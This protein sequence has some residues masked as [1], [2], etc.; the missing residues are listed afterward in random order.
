M[1]THMLEAIFSWLAIP[2]L[3]VLLLA[4]MMSAEVLLDRALRLFDPLRNRNAGPARVSM[5]G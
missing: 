5:N 2:V 1:W 4:A 3:P